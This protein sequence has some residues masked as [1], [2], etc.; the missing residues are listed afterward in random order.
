MAQAEAMAQAAKDAGLAARH[1]VDARGHAALGAR[2][3]DDR[4]P[5]LHG[6]V[7]GPALRRQG[8][9]RTTSSPTRRAHDLPAD[10]VLLGQPHPLRHGAQE[11]ARRQARLHAADGR[12]EAAGH[13]GG[14]HRPLRLRHLQA[15]PRVHRQD[16]RHRRRAPDRRGD[17]GRAL[18]RRSGRRCA[19]TTCRPRSIARFGFP[20]AD[21]LGNMFQFKRDFESEFCGARDLARLARAQPEAPDL[22]AVAGAPTRTGFRSADPSQRKSRETA[23]VAWWG[24]RRPA[25]IDPNSRWASA[26]DGKRPQ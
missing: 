15:R 12:Q 17:G 20:G 18:A 14:G 2:S 7:Q 4:M 13:R 22:R 5:T 26:W 16:G 6:Q 21:D 1:L 9:G 25:G 3:S 24:T 10:L 19:T 8:R 23:S 11:G